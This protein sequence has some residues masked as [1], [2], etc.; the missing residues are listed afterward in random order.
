MS[1]HQN[2]R[3][4]EHNTTVSQVQRRKQQAF[5]VELVERKI[6]ARAQA[7]YNERGHVDGFALQDWV[8][9]ESE[10]LEKNTLALLYRRVRVE[11]EQSNDSPPTTAIASL[12]PEPF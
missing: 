8:Q 3:S 9:A 7:I 1:Y 12:G 6:R 5:I 11:R 10:V 2:M 4:E